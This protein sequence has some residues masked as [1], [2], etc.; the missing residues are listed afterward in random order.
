MV[1]FYLV[2]R[3]PGPAALQEDNGRRK[4]FREFRNLVCVVLSEMAFK[5][6]GI[7]RF[8]TKAKEN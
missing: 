6:H 7:L 2:P 5:S 8:T 4:A 1:G 3:S